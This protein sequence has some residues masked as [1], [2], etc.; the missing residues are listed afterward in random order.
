MNCTADTINI[1]LKMYHSLN[2]LGDLCSEW[3]AL[4]D[5]SSYPNVFRRWEWISTWW[6]WFG[7][8][9][10]LNILL[11]SHG[12]EL[13]G[14]APLYIER[15]RFGGRKIEW[16][17]F[18]GP[19]CPEYLGPI[20]HRDFVEPVIE[21][22]ARHFTEI[23][24]S[25]IAFR[26]VPPDDLATNALIDALSRY[27]PAIRFPGEACPYFIFPQSF[28]ALLKRL[29][30]HRRQRK[31]RQLRRAKEELGVRL[32]VLCNPSTLEQAFPIIERLSASSKKEVGLVSP[33]LNPDYAGFHREVCE[34]L[35]IN[36]L[37][38]VYMLS[39][40]DKPAAFLY[41]FSYHNKFYAFQTGYDSDMDAYSPGDT[42]FQMVYEH[43]I[44]EGL[45]EFDYLRGGEEYKNQFGD[46]QRCTE[47]SLVYRCAG[48]VYAAQ[49]IRLNVI[50]PV[51]R[52]VKQRL[53]R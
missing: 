48:H 10:E 39:F 22:L 38:R 17:G 34:R 52:Q 42:V 12:S 47:T 43:L 16:I 46:L 4:V 3:N 5:A 28:E 29:S 41:G 26:D 25:G 2:D 44:G 23:K 15:G 7:A 53:V 30:S 13:V 33:F 1:S 9:R 11:V 20:I 40:R 8:N 37:A 31:K 51:R 24:W 45:T 50:A 35:S 14:I 49:W 36:A 6:K 32:D 19:T 21:T 27:Y 18:G